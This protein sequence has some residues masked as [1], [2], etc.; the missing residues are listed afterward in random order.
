MVSY[1][2]WV[3]AQITALGLVFSVLSDGAISPLIGTFIGTGVVLLFTVFG[4]MWSVA[5]TDFIQMFIIVV[6]LAVIAVIAG[7]L[8]GGPGKVIELVVEEEMHHFWPP[9]ELKAWMFFLGSGI[10]IMLG[11][12][13][14]QDVFQRVMSAKSEDIA[15]AGPVIG[16]LGYLVFSFVP[17][18]IVAS[19]LLIMPTE[20]TEL[21]KRDPQ[22]VL[23]TLIMT[24]MPKFTQV[25]FFGALL[26]AIMSTASSTILAPAT[27]FVQNILKNVMPNMSDRRELLLMRLAV[28]AFTA[29]VLAYSIYMHGTSIY[30]LVSSSYQVPVVGAF[31]PLIGGLYWKRATNQGAITSIVLGVGTWVLFLSTQ[32]GEHFPQQL[33]GLAMAIVGMWLGSIAPTAG[34]RAA[35]HKTSSSHSA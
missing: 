35:W 10:T 12:I 31:V 1:L 14:Q 7:Y 29:G 32:L 2:G 26:S 8:A 28:L 3:A 11:S 34:N 17:V 30:D 20:A 15:A 25:I 21:I 23:P 19:S 5:V 33:A 22:Q 13:P 9:A 24:H 18:F 6:G 16:G 27:L 4:G